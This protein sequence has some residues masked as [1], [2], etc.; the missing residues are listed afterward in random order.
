MQDDEF[1]WDDEKARGNLVKHGVDF[2][3]AKSVFHDPDLLDVPDESMDYGEERYKALGMARGRLIAVV[4]TLRDGRTRI[5][6]ARAADRKE[7][8]DYARQDPSS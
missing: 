4:Y 3:D 1:E 2:E 7:H 5:I 6:S 8:R